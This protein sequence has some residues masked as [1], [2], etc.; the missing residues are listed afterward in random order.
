MMKKLLIALTV[1]FFL[2]CQKE[3][4]EPNFES[5]DFVEPDEL[6]NH[7]FLMSYGI[8]DFGEPACVLDYQTETIMKVRFY[9]E[10]SALFIQGDT[11][12]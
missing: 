7:I 10:H 6:Q 11:I 2:G 1:L 4:I 3:T 9:P 8:Y 5:W 12:R